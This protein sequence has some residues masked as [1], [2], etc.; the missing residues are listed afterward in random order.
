[1]ASHSIVSRTNSFHLKGL[2]A[3]AETSERAFSAESRG[4]DTD[5]LGQESP[6][7]H[8]AYDDFNCLATTT[9][10]RATVAPAQRCCRTA[11]RGG[12]ANLHGVLEASLFLFGF[13]LGGF[14]Q[15]HAGPSSIFV[16]KLNAGRLQ[17]AAYGE[18][19]GGG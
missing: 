18:L 17:G 1:M 8:A 10:R 5:S 15:P 2:G 19:I 16:N 9:Y 3:A 12:L 13:C 14:A 7:S 6:R 11:G 4:H